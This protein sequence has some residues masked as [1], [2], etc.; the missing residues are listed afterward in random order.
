VNATES[1][2]CGLATNV[3]DEYYKATQ[4]GESGG[5]I[6]AWSPATKQYYPASCSRAP[7]LVR[8]AISGTSDPNAEVDL[9]PSALNAYTP[10]QASAYA[11]SG[12]AGPNG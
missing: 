4:S 3:F 11:A 1:V 5:A 7:G 12:K 6:S 9:S 2:S 8:C 10:Q